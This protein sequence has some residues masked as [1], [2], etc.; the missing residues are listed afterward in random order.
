MIFTWEKN[1]LLPSVLFFSHKEK[2][3]GKCEHVGAAHKNVVNYPSFSTVFCLNTLKG[4]KK[5]Y[6]FNLAVYHIIHFS[7]KI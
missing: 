5:L 6:H 2:N 1:K 7:N 3:I 4:N